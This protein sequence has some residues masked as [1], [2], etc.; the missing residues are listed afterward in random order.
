MNSSVPLILSQSPELSTPLPPTQKSSA[1]FVAIE[2]LCRLQ[3]S[4]KPVNALLNSVLTESPLESNDRQLAVTIIYGLLRNRQSLDRMLQHLCTQPLKKL[5][6]FIHQTLRVGLFQILYLERIPESAAVNE[7]VKAVQAARLPKQLQG[8]VNGVLRNS[9]RKRDE[10]LKI[11]NNPNQPIL[12]HPDW[13]C[14]RWEKR[15]G[16]EETL[17]ICRQNN[18]QAPLAL[19]VNSSKVDRETLLAQLHQSGITAHIGKFCEDTLILEDFHGAVT[20]LPGFAEGLF[21]IQDQGAQLLPQLLGPMGEEGEYLDGCAG[22]GGKTSVMA[23]LA[24][25]VRA[26]I[27][28]VEPDRARQEKFKENMQRL[29]PELTIPLFRVSL[30]EFAASTRKRFHGILLDAP[31]SG[32]GVIGRHPDIRWNRRVEDFSHYQETQLELLQS[33]A[34]L[35]I[36]RGILV[37]GTCSLEKEE[38]EEVIDYFL[39]AN[40]NFS[41]EDCRPFLP[42]AAQQLVKGNYFTPLPNAEIDGFFG[43]IL[44]KQT[45][46]S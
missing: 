24:A 21:Q 41:L 5:K 44:V 31:C 42:P 35:L 45:D 26:N 1:R 33:A 34:T 12:N 30:Q 8:F 25:P 27:S 10:L 28:A 9:I 23:Q 2:T 4:R 17:R 11:I 13:M 3:K 15:Y 39:T 22:V 40:G 38:N 43:A 29:H 37:Y 6:P 18:E 36:P 14:S 16:R 19:Q 20:R 7:S 46:T 32:T